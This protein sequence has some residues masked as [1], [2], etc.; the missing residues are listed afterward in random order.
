M[1]AI[2]KL[3]TCV[4]REIHLELSIHDNYKLLNLKLTHTTRNTI[5]NF[6]LTAF[7]KVAPSFATN[8]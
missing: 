4:R 7:V 2:I 5:V 1:L 6:I 3:T 8:F